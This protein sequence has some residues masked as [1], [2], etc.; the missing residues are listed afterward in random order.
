MRTL[1]E[2]Y[3]SAD[4]KKEK[5]VPV[6]ECADSVKAD[7]RALIT[8]TVGKE[9][10]HPNTT[11][12][13]IRWIQLFFKPDDEKFI[14]QIAFGSFDAHGD[15]IE[16]A[17]KGCVFSEAA[18]SVTARIKKRGM[19]HAISLCNIHGVWESYKPIFIS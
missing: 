14:Y 7:E 1:G 18:L 6:I 19:L 11:E 16:G 4:W 3:Q 2:F 12:H 13:H 9:I 5:H 8:I 15:S 17:N 10:P